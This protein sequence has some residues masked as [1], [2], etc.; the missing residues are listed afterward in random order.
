MHQTNNGKIA[1]RKELMAR[2]PDAGEEIDSVLPPPKYKPLPLA[3]HYDSDLAYGRVARRSIGGVVRMVD[4]KATIH[5]TKRKTN[6]ETLTYGAE[7]NTGRVDI[8]HCQETRCMLRSVGVEAN[9][10]T[11]WYGDNKSAYEHCANK[12]AECISRHSS[13]SF[14]KMRESVAAGIITPRHV[15]CSEENIPLTL[16]SRHIII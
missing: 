5:K 6:V 3:A 11:K 4:K 12:N 16:E 15:V 10:P 2:Y 13:M 9:S 1:S 8:E 14:H 7:L